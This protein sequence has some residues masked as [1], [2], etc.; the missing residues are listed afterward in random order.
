MNPFGRLLCLIFTLATLSV[1]GVD[2]ARAQQV[3]AKANVK[4]SIKKPIVVTLLQ[5]LDFGTVILSGGGAADTFA[6][7]RTGALTCAAGA[8]CT[9][10]AQEARY[11]VTGS[12]QAT[13]TI[14]A[15][16]FDLVNGA[17]DAIRFYPDAPA[18]I[19]LPNS[20]NTGIDFGVGGTIS[21]PQTAAGA[22][23]GT[24]TVT[25]EYQ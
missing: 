23:V 10:A 12:N 22:Y 4:V 6:I 18:T 1:A 9:G 13:V 14:N 8:T 7:S 5:S 25:A 15:P 17:G 20:G 3:Q 16:D 2:E 19:D 24:M 11:N 21:V